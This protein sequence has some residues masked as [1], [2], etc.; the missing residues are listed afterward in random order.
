MNYIMKIFK[1]LEESI[2]LIKGVTETIKNQRK[3]RKSGYLSTL[4]DTLDASSLGNLLTGKAVKTKMPRKE[5]IRPC[6]G[7][8]RTG[9]DAIRVC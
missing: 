1:H 5:A 6:K 9:E 3:E 4:L 2:W 7:T 8:I